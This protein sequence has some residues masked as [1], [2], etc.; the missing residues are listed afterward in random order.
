MDTIRKYDI[1]KEKRMEYINNLS[2]GIDIHKIIGVEIKE[3]HS[4]LIVNDVN[5]IIFEDSSHS[6]YIIWGY[7]VYGESYT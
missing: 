4:T 5:T 6:V 3:Y 1:R 2:V 7:N